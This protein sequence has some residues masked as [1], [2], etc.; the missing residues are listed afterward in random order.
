M[1]QQFGDVTFE[2]SEKKVLDMAKKDL[3][4]KE[5]IAAQAI[6][7]KAIM[8]CPISSE[9]ELEQKKKKHPLSTHLINTIK[10][11]KSKYKDKGFIVFAGGLGARHAHLVEYGTQKWPSGHPFLRPAIEQSEFEVKRIFESE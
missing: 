2:F 5:R 8:L 9:E 4:N 3:E 10:V 6:Y 11:Y 1:K 7:N